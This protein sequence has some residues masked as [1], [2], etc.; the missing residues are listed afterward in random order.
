MKSNF[1]RGE[2]TAGFGDICNEVITIRN[3]LSRLD[4]AYDEFR[5]NMVGTSNSNKFAE[6]KLDSGAFLGRLG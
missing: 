3:M 4:I 1:G 5:G 2:Y 6:A